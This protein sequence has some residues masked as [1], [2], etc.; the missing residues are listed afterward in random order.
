MVG[1]IGP[2]GTRGGWRRRRATPALHALGLLAGS[3]LFGSLVLFFGKGAGRIVPGFATATGIT[4]LIGAVLWHLVGGEPLQWKR[5]VPPGRL[6]SMGPVIG[7]FA[8]GLEL[9]VIVLSRIYTPIPLIIIGFSLTTHG[10]GAVWLLAGSY[11]LGRVAAFGVG[12]IALRNH[13]GVDVW[14]HYGQIRRVIHFAT[15]AIGAVVATSFL[16][17]V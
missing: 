14:R 2:M 6:S 13:P 3:T 7:S 5:Q 8:Y 9:G 10:H 11:G 12:V 16:N 1:T 4:L 15:L 17:F